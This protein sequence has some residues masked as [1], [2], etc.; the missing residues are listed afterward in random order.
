MNLHACCQLKHQEKEP[1][2]LHAI[3]R[4]NQGH[5]LTVNVI[6]FITCLLSFTSVLP[7]LVT[8]ASHYKSNTLSSR[9]GMTV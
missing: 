5:T 9:L 3:I 4:N 8:T 2:N 7:C 1:D 6:S